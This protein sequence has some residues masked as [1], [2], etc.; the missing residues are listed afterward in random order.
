MKGNSFFVYLI[1]GIFLSMSLGYMAYQ[2]A[3]ESGTDWT[4]SYSRYD[5]IP[6][7]TFILYERLSDVFPNTKIEPVTVTPYSHLTWELDTLLSRQSYLFIQRSFYPDPESRDALLA[8]VASGNQVFVAAHFFETT[9]LDTLGLHAKQSY[10]IIEQD[11][12]SLQFVSP[13]HHPKEPYKF[14]HTGYI[15]YFESFDENHTSILATASNA[16]LPIMLRV[17]YGAG[18]FYL[19]TTPLQFTNLHMLYTQRGSNYV[20][21][22]FSH[23]LDV[24]TVYWDEYYTYTNAVNGGKQRDILRFIH[25]YPSLTWAFWLLVMGLI[26]FVAFEAKRKQRIIPKVAPPANTSLEFVETIGRLYYQR[27]DHKNLLQKKYQILLAHIRQA[28]HLPTEKIDKDF[29]IQ[30]ATK[31]GISRAK[32]EILFN[33][34][35]L[36][37]QQSISE[38]RL[39]AINKLIED[40]YESAKS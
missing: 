39:I 11:T 27:G 4:E 3:Q 33:Q 14:H 24:E 38:E 28:Y 32:I 8:F 1:I 26:L 29:M 9:L 5:K 13:Y 35:N 21:H 18:Y 16:H 10:S 23:I 37:L 20:A 15:N 31:S 2:M 40:F 6:Y 19:S 25:S 22:S 7:G 30:L 34:L 12:L 17:S 36:A